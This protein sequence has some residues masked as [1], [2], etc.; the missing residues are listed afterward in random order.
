MSTSVSRLRESVPTSDAEPASSPP[1]QP[2]VVA[3]IV[4]YSDRRGYCREAVKAALREGCETV[5]LVC[6]GVPPV[7]IA[8]LRTSWGDDDP[9]VR[10]VELPRNTGSAGGFACGLEFALANCGPELLWL[11]DD[12]NLPAAGSLNELIAARTRIIDAGR[13]EE[14]VVTALRESN[15]RHRD[16]GLNNKDVRA[17]YPPPGSFMWFDVLQRLFTRSQPSRASTRPTLPNGWVTLPYGPYGGLL[18]SASTARK[19]GVPDQTLIVYEDDTDFTAR[20]GQM[21]IPL[22]LVP[23]SRVGDLDAKWIDSGQDRCS[24]PL[25]L[26]RAEDSTRVYYSVRNRVIFDRAQA[27]RESK[28]AVARYYVN[29]MIYLAIVTILGL[30]SRNG[31]QLPTVLVAVLRAERGVLAK[32]P[33]LPAT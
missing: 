22:V 15:P 3:I 4:T 9:H 5:V 11:L 16:V 27:R 7:V 21:G 25:R 1:R 28:A 8:D 6:N 12:D 23:G 29:M 20:I 18:L 32:A 14:V 26:L 17:V 13:A 24:G 30:A 2:P 10:V 31:R 33:P 19:A